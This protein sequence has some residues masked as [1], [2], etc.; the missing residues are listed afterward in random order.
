M[1]R[2][3]V[4][5]LVISFLCLTVMISSVSFAGETWDPTLRN[6]ITTRSMMSGGVIAIAGDYPQS[7]IS[8]FKIL[9]KGGTAFDAAVAMAATMGIVNKQMNDIFGGD[10]MIMVYSAK[11]KQ[12]FVYNATGWAPKAATID[13]YMDIGGI[14]EKGILSVHVPGAF[15]GWMTLL[16]DYGTLP[17]SEILAPAI[18]VAENGY[19]LDGSAASEAWMGMGMSTF[20]EEARKVFAPNGVPVKRGELVYQK[21][22]A[23]LLTKVSKMGYQEAEDYVYR[24]DL[25]KTIVDFAKS[26]GGIL[27]LEDFDDF[28]AEKVAPISTNY[29]GIDVFV[30]PPNCQGMVLLEAL[31]ILEGY[32]VKSLGHNT[33]EYMDLLTQALN[34]GLE[35]RNNFMGDPRFVDNPMGMITK[36]YAKVRREKDMQPGKA[37][38]DK[39]VAGK[40]VE[41][42]QF[43]REKG[44]DTTFLA[45]ADAE[46]NIVACTTSICDIW[47]SATM[48]PG[49]GIMLNNRMSYYLLEEELP[50]HLEPRKRTVQTITPS[51]ALKDG[52]P[53]FVFG[54]PGGDLQEQSKLQAFFNVF[55]FGMT[56]Q[57]AAEAPRFQSMH[58][59]ALL[60]AFKGAPPRTIGIEGRVPA[61]EREKMTQMGY[62]VVSR[63]DWEY[64]GLIGIIKIDPETGWKETGVDPRGENTA[65][66]W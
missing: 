38:P 1:S 40:P 57:E 29:K 66:A 27:T 53:C 30:C 21:D 11:E 39:L 61:A 43:Y 62:N 41:F 34:L 22:Y 3:F 60:A 25:T 32:D 18:H 47:G 17:L 24:G 56:P 28:K 63:Y 14:P 45:V 2:K 35:D 64:K 50:N 8:A 37:M 9:E 44:G 58:P 10:A 52:S 46:G 55:E 6:P 26:Q 42:N 54:T 51:I 15:S 23:K 65:I 36:E 19:P 48:V 20:N 7:A 31:N 16:K 49:T 59:R 5:R 12:L 13:H 4:S 33:A